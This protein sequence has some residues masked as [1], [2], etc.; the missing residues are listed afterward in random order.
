APPAAQSDAGAGHGQGEKTGANV[1]AWIVPDLRLFV[2]RPEGG[3]VS[4]GPHRVKV[5][6]D[7]VIRST[8]YETGKEIAAVEYILEEGGEKKRYEVP[9]KDKKDRPNYRS[10]HT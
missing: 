7:K 10:Q 1:W 6:S 3:T 9:E 4:T 5:L 8:E 2:K